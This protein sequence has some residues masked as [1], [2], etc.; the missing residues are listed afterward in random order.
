MAARP[1]LD[2]RDTA[3]GASLARAALVAAAVCFVGTTSGTATRSGAPVAAGTAARSGLRE[4]LAPTKAPAPASSLAKRFSALVAA[5]APSRFLSLGGA[6]DPGRRVR[7][8]FARGRGV[9]NAPA[10]TNASALAIIVTAGLANYDEARPP[11]A[12][13]L[14]GPFGNRGRRKRIEARTRA[15]GGAASGAGRRF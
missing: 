3:R 5:A 2:R 8:A 9:I 6:G 1:A 4:G 13:R 11:K 15:L 14:G 12:G 10:G 7:A